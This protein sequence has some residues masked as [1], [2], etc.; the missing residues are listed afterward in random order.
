[1]APQDRVEIAAG[2][3]PLPP[4]LPDGLQ[5]EEA[6]PALSGL[7][8][9][10]QRLVDQRGQPVQEIQAELPWGHTASAESSVQPPV[11]T[12]SRANRRRSAASSRS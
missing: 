12:D 9:A 5:H 11:N 4:K 1:M 6:G 3:K 8:P 7:G 2:P 10:H